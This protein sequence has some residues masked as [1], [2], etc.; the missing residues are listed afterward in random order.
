MRRIAVIGGGWAGCAAAVAL[1]RR[2]DARVTLFEASR[3]LGG[4]A[5][6]VNLDGMA[7]DNGQ[8]I[9]LGAY[10]ETLRL[11]REVGVD[12]GQALL[13]LPL[14]MRY[15]PH[16][17]GMDF[18]TWRLPAPFHML[19]S[20]LSARGLAAGDK[21]ALARFTSAARWMGWRQD[22]DGSV[23]ELLDRFDQ[24]ERLVT[25]MWRP[26]CIAALNTPPERASA[27]VFLNVL[28][29]SLGASRRSASDM[30]VPR[31]D[32]GALFPAAAAD[33][34]ARHGGEVRLGSAIKRLRRSGDAWLLSSAAGPDAA[35][36]DVIV[37]TAPH[38]A[39]GLL[40]GLIDTAP[41][42][43]M[44]YE[45]I[46]TCYL[47]YGDD[48][49]LGHPMFAL[50]DDGARAHWGQFVF[51]RGMLDERQRGLL[52]VVVSASSEAI[53]QG[54]EALAAAIASQLAQS[55]GMPVLEHPHWSKVVS[56]KRATFACRPD[57][58]RLPNDT[59]LP[60]LLLA[61]DHTTGDYPATLEGAVRSGLA[62]AAL[63]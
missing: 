58:A 4:R 54:H 49:S 23:S 25:L 22:R 15:A 45:P 37:A 11:M 21:L 48:C 30:L 6:Q 14:Q 12:P 42:A 28:R 56:E 19:A 52:A 60:G 32:L 26:L 35:F 31:A 63:L 50:V 53:A 34:I 27:Q 17:G 13:R 40:E 55:F 8:H 46:T 18:V 9:L 51:D 3:A 2:G 61:G 43:A 62:A 39:A 10:T 1:C 24:T 47:R 16:A 5:R 57:L 38:H 20:L 59:G 29:D 36:D 44:Q 33:Y 7:L 41:L